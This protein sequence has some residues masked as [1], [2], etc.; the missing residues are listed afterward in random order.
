MVVLKTVAVISMTPT[1][2]RPKPPGL[3]LP[4]TVG[5]FSFYLS[6]VD[7]LLRHPDDTPTIGIILCKTRSRV[8]VEYTLR[9]QNRPIGVSEFRLGEAL[10]QELQSELPTVEQLEAQL[11][12]AGPESVKAPD[13]EPEEGG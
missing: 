3:G 12:D 11:L 13:Q 9:D 2:S 1:V 8:I 4:E 7:D 5:A 10:P 6:A